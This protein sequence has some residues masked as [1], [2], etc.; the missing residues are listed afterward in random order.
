MESPPIEPGAGQSE[1]VQVEVRS[2]SVPN[3]AVEI[4][5]IKQKLLA[6]GF[7]P[8]EANR[9]AQA[10][11]SD[12]TRERLQKAGFGD[13]EIDKMIKAQSMSAG[14]AGIGYV[15]TVAASSEPNIIIYH[16]AGFWTRLCAMMIDGLILSIPFFLITM[17]CSLPVALS[18]DP[19]PDKVM[20]S[21]FGNLVGFILQWLYFAMMEC[22]PRM[23]TYGKSAMNIM[24]LDTSGD[25]ISFGRASARY[26]S[27]SLSL[28]TFLVGYIM[29][30]FTPEKRALHDYVAGTMVVKRYRYY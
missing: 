29:A 11:R 5:A 9:M 7:S 17:V 10:A 14:T 28:I 12:S 25:Q 1:P 20:L 19:G 16:Y 3:T 13:A 27:K 6:S 21:L 26:F 30:G 2:D 22:G 15:P 24:V 23:G 18:K 4:N 8:Y